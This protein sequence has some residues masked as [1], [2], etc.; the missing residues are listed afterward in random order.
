LRD[1]EGILDNEE[2]DKDDYD[3]RNMAIDEGEVGDRVV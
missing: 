1:P 2:F 3:T